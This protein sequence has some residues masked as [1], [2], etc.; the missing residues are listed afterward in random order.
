[1]YVA[2][3]KGSCN[4][5]WRLR[6]ICGTKPIFFTQWLVTYGEFILEDLFVISI[7]ISIFNGFLPI[8]LWKAKWIRGYTETYGQGQLPKRLSEDT[9][10]YCYRG[11]WTVFFKANCSLGF[12]Q[13]RQ[14]IFAY[15]LRNSVAIHAFSFSFLHSPSFLAIFP[16]FLLLF[17]LPP[18]QL[19]LH[20]SKYTPEKF[21]F[22]GWPVLFPTVTLSPHPP[23]PRPCFWEAFGNSEG[24]HLCHC[25]SGVQDVR[26]CHQ[27]VSPLHHNCS[28]F[29]CI[30]S[31]VYTRR[32]LEWAYFQILITSGIRM[33]NRVFLWGRGREEGER[34]A[35]VMLNLAI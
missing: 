24:T 2:E 10:I 30:D 22:S 23:S 20:T 25:G 34:R 31:D 8:C 18:S 15:F 21:H 16:R 3:E 19:S 7:F 6:E 26:K 11:P 1:M 32:G 4:V 17:S 9:V 12:I 13:K 28:S 27:G 5:T 33:S 29:L 35:R 14:F